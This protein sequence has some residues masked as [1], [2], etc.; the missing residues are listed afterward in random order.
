MHE[1]LAKTHTYGDIVAIL[2]PLDHLV[3]SVRRR[4]WA[5]SSEEARIDRGWTVR[6]SGK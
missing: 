3:T 5:G 4:E 2:C 6:C 1:G